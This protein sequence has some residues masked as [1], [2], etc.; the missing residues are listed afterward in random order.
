MGYFWAG[1]GFENLFFMST[2]VVEQLSF[3]IVP[4]ILNFH[5]DL[6]WAHFFY[7]LGP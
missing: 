3:S 4:S 1:V 7:F 6:F 2:H 5:F